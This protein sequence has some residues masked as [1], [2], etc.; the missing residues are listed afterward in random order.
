MF[1]VHDLFAVCFVC[2][3]ILAPTIGI[4]AML[5]CVELV[6]G[7]LKP[8]AHVLRWFGHENDLNLLAHGV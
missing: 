7:A 3:A 4:R 5:E 8:D 1:P 2:C 6:R